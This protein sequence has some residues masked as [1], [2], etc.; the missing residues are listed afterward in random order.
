MPG[1]NLALEFQS[2]VRRSQGEVLLEDLGLPRMA[3]MTLNRAGIYTMQDLINNKD[4]LDKIPNFG[5]GK[6][7]M[8]ETWLE[9]LNRK[10]SEE[11]DL[12]TPQQNPNQEVLNLQTRNNELQQEN[13]AIKQRIVKKQR[14]LEEY[15]R[16]ITEREQLLQKEQELDR[17]LARLR[18][19]QHA[20]G[21]KLTKTTNS[22]K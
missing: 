6:R 22:G 19:E 21:P 11:G 9:D 20:T 10:K 5:T 16:L 2:L 13:D 3:Y 4:R 17:Q 18:G 1:E 8:V 15:Q 12:I 7:T 14:L